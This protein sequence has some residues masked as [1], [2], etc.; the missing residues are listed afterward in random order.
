M[1]YS[2]TFYDFW[3]LSSG[4]SAGTALDSLVVKD[5]NGL[6]YLPGKTLKGLVR[7]VMESMDDTSLVKSIFGQ[8]GENMANSYF[9]NATLDE[10]TKAYLSSNPHLKKQLFDKI[11]STKIDKDGI[12]IDKSLREIE[13]VVPLRLTGFID[14]IEREKI[15]KAVMMIKQIGL[16]RNRGLGRCKMEIIDEN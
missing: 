16:N 2:I 3:H 4:M 9:G 12:A 5:S 11:T 1:R 7:E 6:P 15:Q 8:E 13:V 14:S 10:N